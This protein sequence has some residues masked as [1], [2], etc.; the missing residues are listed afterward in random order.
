M[1]QWQQQDKMRITEIRSSNPTRGYTDAKVGSQSPKYSWYT[2]QL[3][4]VSLPLADHP[5]LPNDLRNPIDTRLCSS[6]GSQKYKPLSLLTLLTLYQ[7]SDSP[8]AILFPP[9]VSSLITLEIDQ[10]LASLVN[11]KCATK[12]GATQRYCDIITHIASLDSNHPK[13]PY[14]LTTYGIYQRRHSALEYF[15]LIL[16]NQC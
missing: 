14:L 12:E 10:L 16:V 8:F 15:K 11:Y 5:K 7:L 4:T 13:K 2:L 3:F 6:N 1:I 9:Y